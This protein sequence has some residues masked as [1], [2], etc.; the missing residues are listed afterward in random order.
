M[1]PV[2]NAMTNITDNSYQS[3]QNPESYA[4]QHSEG[5][6]MQYSQQMESMPQYGYDNSYQNYSNNQFSFSHPPDINNVNAT[7]KIELR[8]QNLHLNFSNQLNLDGSNK[9]TTVPAR[10]TEGSPLMKPQSQE[11]N[12]DFTSRFEFGQ[13]YEMHTFSE[14]ESEKDEVPG[15]NYPDQWSKFSPS[16]KIEPNLKI[17]Q[18][19]EKEVTSRRKSSALDLLETE[20]FYKHVEEQVK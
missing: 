19:T 8:D 6:A 7:N 9:V 18:N 12:Q 10:I 4:Y 5:E 15:K 3:V 14:G 16:N 17:L 13:N 1:S 20:D 2:P 11:V